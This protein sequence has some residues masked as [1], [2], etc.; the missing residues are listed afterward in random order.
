VY[1]PF[2]VLIPTFEP[3]TALKDLR[4]PQEQLGMALS[5]VNSWFMYSLSMTSS[6]SLS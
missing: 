3:Y 2:V 4:D 5:A 1:W 6:F